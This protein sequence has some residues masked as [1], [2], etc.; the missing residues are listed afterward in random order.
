MVAGS[1][2]FMGYS[3]YSAAARRD[4]RRAHLKAADYEAALQ[5]TVAVYSNVRAFTPRSEEALL[6]ALEALDRAA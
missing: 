1:A 4:S 5:R 3:Y 6:P 2:A